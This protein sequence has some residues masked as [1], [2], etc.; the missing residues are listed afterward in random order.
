MTATTHQIPLDN[1]AA[2]AGLGRPGVLARS[3]T[4]AY[5][6][7]AYALFFIAILYAIGFVGNWVVPK[8]I[9]SGAPGA[10]VPSLVINGLL[11]A[12]FVVQHTVMARPAFKRWITRVIPAAV[13][14]S[15]FVLLASGALLLAFW[16]WRPLPQTVWSVEHPAL[17]WGLSGVSLLGWGIVLLSSF[18]VSHFDLFGLRQV[19]LRFTGREYAPVGF[20]LVGLY[21]LVRHPLMLGFLIAFWATPHMTV[22]HLFFAVMT[23]LYIFMGTWFEERDLIA[24]HGEDYLAYKRS[25]RGLV[26]LPKGAPTAREVCSRPGACPVRSGARGGMDAACYRI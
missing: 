4:L 5:G 18:M 24:E 3:A 25:V 16:Q 8:S 12:V 1:P 15:T 9:D 6:L 23:T 14:R 17:V 10:L 13:E 26:P 22:G 19:W 7:A 2:Q 11:L 21:K 20:R